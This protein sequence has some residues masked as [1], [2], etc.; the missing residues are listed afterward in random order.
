MCPPLTDHEKR[1]A[2]KRKPTQ[3]TIGRELKI[4]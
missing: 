2:Y 3:N 4:S 1:E